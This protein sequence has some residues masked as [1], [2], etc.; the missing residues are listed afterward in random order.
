[1]RL[2]NY[3]GMNDLIFVNK[4]KFK[5]YGSMYIKKNNVKW[6]ALVVFLK[7]ICNEVLSTRNIH[8]CNKFI[9]NQASHFFLLPV[10]TLYERIQIR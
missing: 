8:L 6:F 10:F 7:I 2:E 3:D 9:V 4:Q 5:K 1:M